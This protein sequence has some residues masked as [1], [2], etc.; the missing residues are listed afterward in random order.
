MRN[1]LL[2]F[3]VATTLSLSGYLVWE[4]FRHVPVLIQQVKVPVPVP[5]GDV[6]PSPVENPTPTPTPMVT[7]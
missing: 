3:F 2:G 7:D 5:M 4:H 1:F 6:E